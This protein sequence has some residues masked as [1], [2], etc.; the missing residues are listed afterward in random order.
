MRKF[1]TLVVCFLII[2][3]NANAQSVH[4]DNLG[5]ELSYKTIADNLHRIE[6]LTKVEKPDVKVLVEQIDYLNETFAKLSASRQDIDIEIKLIEKRIDALGNQDGESAEAKIIAQKR[7]EFNKELT[8]EKTRLSEIDLLSAKIEEVNLR[9]FDIRNQKLWGNLLKVN[10]C[11][12]NPTILWNVNRELVVLLADIAKSPYDAYLEYKQNNGSGA[13]L[14]MAQFFGLLVLIVIIGYYLRIM[15]I[16]RWGYRS[17]I[18]NLRLG[19]KIAAAMAV[20]CAYGIIPTAIVGYCWYHLSLIAFWDNAFFKVV[21]QTILSYALFVIMGRAFARVI[22]TPYNEK[23]RLIKISTNKAKHLFKAINFTIYTVGLFAIL[24]AIALVQ[25]YSLDLL[26]YLVALSASLKAVCMVLLAYVYFMSDAQDAKLMDEAKVS[27]AKSRASRIGVFVMLFAVT[28]IVLAFIGYSRLAFFVVDHTLLSL[29]A[30][31]VYAILRRFIYDIGRRILFMGLWV[32]DFHVRRIF[33]RKVDFW[34]GFAVEP[35]ITLAFIAGLLVL[36]GVPTDML[37]AVIYKAIYGFTVGGVKIS[38]VSIFWGI[39]AF[40]LCLWVIRFI[41]DRI[42][43]KILERTSIDAGTKH[44]LAAGFA[45]IGYVLSGLLAIAIMGGNLSNIALIA[46][47]LSV[48]IGLGLQDIVNNFVSGIIMLFERPIK[49]GDWVVINGQEGQVKRINIRSTEIETFHR[50][51]LIIPNS[52][53]LSNAVTNLTHQNNNA[54]YTIKVGVAYGSDVEKVKQLLLESVLSHPKVAKKPA[55][56]VLFTDFGSSSL[57]FEVRYY[58]NDLWNSWTSPSDIR[59][60][61]N[62]KF[63]ENGIEIPFSQ[64]VIHQAKKT[65]K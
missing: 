13:G 42:E 65:E 33:L 36:W 46:G 21:L 32:K 61:I 37:R 35:L 40:A 25:H 22:L 43:F 58:V 50:S 63:I 2:C 38:L 44:S 57:D 39:V 30:L 29:A 48:G 56:Y 59:Y 5:H 6:K 14:A 24:M 45:Y 1:L 23:W 54:R 26:S 64:V 60:I 28:V 7:A 20:W 52:Q 12:I 3:F 11:L 47:A 41:Q 55:P 4:V 62:Q 8:L 16:K 17:D 53:V 51:S 27:A 31:F 15:V 49:V 19:R 34:F 9:I 18:E 10:L